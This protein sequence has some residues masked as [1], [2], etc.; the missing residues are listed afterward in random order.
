MNRNKTSKRNTVLVGFIAYCIFCVAEIITDFVFVAN[1][2]GY[3]VRR[4]TLSYLGQ[5][6]SPIGHWVEYWGIAFTLLLLL[7]AWGFYTAYLDKN[8]IWIPTLMIVL[9]ALGEGIGS[10]SFP[11]S[12]VESP[13]TMDGRLHNIF[14]GIGD[15]AMILLPF[16]LLLYFKEDKSYCF[17]RYLR[18]VSVIGIGLVSCFLS[19]KFFPADNIF[20]DYKGIWQRLFLLD[21]HTF[22]LVLGFKMIKND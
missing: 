1:Y 2:P 3:D 14:G 5:S 9:Y 22:L 19:A 7:F 15:A 13:M 8:R 18:V 11:I 12:P 20:T 21:Y 10:G 4:Q 16:V 6:N 17:R